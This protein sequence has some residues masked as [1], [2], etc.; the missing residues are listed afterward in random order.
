MHY[1]CPGIYLLFDFTCNL[2]YVNLDATF[3]KIEAITSKPNT[4]E[5]SFIYN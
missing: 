2:R 5:S 3:I 4:K 1:L